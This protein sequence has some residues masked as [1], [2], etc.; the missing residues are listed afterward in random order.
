M[1]TPKWAEKYIEEA[2]AYINTLPEG[3]QVHQYTG[4]DLPIPPIKWRTGKV[5]KWFTDDKGKRAKRRRSSGICY[6]AHIT[7]VSG[8]D[9]NDL[10]MVILHELGHWTLDRTKGGYKSIMHGPA[11][12]DLAWKLYFHFK[13]PIRQCRKREANYRKGSEAGYQRI[14]ELLKRKEEPTMAES[15]EY[16]ENLL[17]Q[18]QKRISEIEEE[19]TRLNNEKDQRETVIEEAREGLAKFYPGTNDEICASCSFKLD[20]T[21]SSVDCD[22]PMGEC[23]LE[24]LG[25]K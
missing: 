15:K 21:Q 4:R 16:Y 24:R 17:N 7:I 18:N 3:L 8:K 20:P 10:K 1:S 5:S 22:P 13:L 23:P 2:V 14:K 25:R 19:I 11:F 6:Q 12:W 9:L